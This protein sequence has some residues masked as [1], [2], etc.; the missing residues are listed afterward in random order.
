MV[1]GTRI[2][3]GQQAAHLHALI[4]KGDF[5]EATNCLGDIHYGTYEML[6]RGFRLEEKVTLYCIQSN[7]RAYSD[8]RGVIPTK[9]LSTE[10]LME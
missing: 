5:E 1:R 9:D 7:A 4:D 3:A 6:S 10:Q 2:P 8:P